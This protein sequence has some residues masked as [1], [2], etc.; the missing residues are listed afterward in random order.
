MVKAKWRNGSASGILDGSKYTVFELEIHITT[1]PL[2]FADQAI[3]F[4]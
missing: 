1:L 4:S 2:H 3:R